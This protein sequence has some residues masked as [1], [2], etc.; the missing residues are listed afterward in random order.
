MTFAPTG[1]ERQTTSFVI[2]ITST[3]AVNGLYRMI[4]KRPS[5]TLVFTL[6]RLDKPKHLAEECFTFR[7]L[8]GRQS[9][10]SKNS[11]KGIP[12]TGIVKMPFAVLFKNILDV[13]IWRL[14]KD[15]QPSVSP[16][17]LFLPSFITS[18]TG[19]MGPMRTSNISYASPHTFPATGA[20][21]FWAS[22]IGIPSGR[23]GFSVS[24]ACHYHRLI[25]RQTSE[26]IF[27]LS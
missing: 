23:D 18:F 22:P 11:H 10:P 16:V 12:K 24:V 17:R 9:C 19:F 4:M 21:C 26:R 5:K 2:L 20:E 7:K 1:V 14:R 15:L 6:I 8:L 13:G 27:R 25:P 3:V